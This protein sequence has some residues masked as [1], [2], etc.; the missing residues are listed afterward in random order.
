MDLEALG[1]STERVEPVASFVND[2]TRF[3]SMTNISPVTAQISSFFDQKLIFSHFNKF[4]RGWEYLI[5]LCAI[6]CPMEMSFIYLI[7]PD[8][9][10]Q[11]YC[12][13]FIID[14]LF[15]IDDFIIRRTAFLFNGEIIKSTAAISEKYGLKYLIIHIVSIIPLGWIGIVIHDK[16]VYLVLSINRLLRLHR[17]WRAY[18]NISS[19]LPY[20]GGPMSIL[21]LFFFIIF[22]VHFFA[23]IFIILGMSQGYEK[24]FLAPFHLRGF[25]Q[26]QLYFT[27][28]YFVMTTILTIGFGD[29]S[30][31]TTPE[32]VITIFVQIIGVSMNAAI[33]SYMVAILIDSAS[34]EFVQKYKVVQDYLRFK[35]VNEER[36]QDVRHFFQYQYDTA[37]GN[38]NFRR[39]L[40]MLPASLRNSIKLEMT[41]QFFDYTNC[42]TSLSS[43]QLVRV[44][45][46]MSFKTFSPNDIICEENDIVDKIIFFKSGVFGIIV[47]GVIVVTQEANKGYVYGEKEMLM[48][49]HRPT[50]L[51]AVTY[52]ECWVLRID[53][54]Q[55]M[56]Q[57]R[58]EM[59]VRILTSLQLAYPDSY[60]T[61]LRNLIVDE[62]LYHKMLTTDFGEY[63]EDLSDSSTSES[64]KNGSHTKRKELM[65][66]FAANT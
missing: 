53:E 5:L 57:N 48:A 42:F 63:L 30:P 43:K 37:G 14:I 29:I 32:V 2:P 36:R 7:I 40:K 35:D 10:I 64:A 24:S 60:P 26:L 65:A 31:V 11:Y 33:T 28:I 66:K 8:I 27:S 9:P 13:I 50:G 49:A 25:D 23:C 61:I 12:I 4:R 46:S 44:A 47:D 52:V 38:G 59:R 39:I 20:A 18:R 17:G 15:A 1:F 45:D 16:V 34:A 51:M 55:H 3:G 19:L 22:A 54:L 41:R 6:L 56:I 62:K 21:P 58:E